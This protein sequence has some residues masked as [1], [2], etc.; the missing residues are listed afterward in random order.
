MA[1]ST[2]NIC[3][4]LVFFGDGLKRIN[5]LC[6]SVM[7]SDV[8]DSDCQLMPDASDCDDDDVAGSN[9]LLECVLLAAHENGKEAV[10]KLLSQDPVGVNNILCDLCAN[11]YLLHNVCLAGNEELVSLLI[12]GY[13]VDINAES[14]LVSLCCW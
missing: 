6:F 7:S 3:S 4:R 11:D 13:Y 1:A 2:G 5:F 14:P 10:V 9:K 8:V 12:G